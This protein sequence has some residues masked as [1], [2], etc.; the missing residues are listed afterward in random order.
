LHLESTDY[1]YLHGVDITLAARKGCVLESV[2]AEQNQPRL[3]HQNRKTSS[4][5]RTFCLL[6]FLIRRLHLGQTEL[7]VAKVKLLVGRRSSSHIHES[8]KDLIAELESRLGNATTEYLSVGISYKHSAF[9]TSRSSTAAINGLSY[10]TTTTRIEAH[11]V[12]KRHCAES[13]WSHQ[14]KS[15]PNSSRVP[16]PLI[17]LINAHY[18]PVKAARLICKI[19]TDPVSLAEVNWRQLNTDCRW[20]SSSDT[21]TAIRRKSSRDMLHQTAQ[22]ENFASIPESKQS[23]QAGFHDTD[24]NPGILPLNPCSDLDPARKIWSDMRKTSRA[25]GKRCSYTT[26][27]SEIGMDGGSNGSSDV[28][29]SV[30]KE[31][32]RILE[33]AL[34]NKRSLGAD[35]LRS[36]ASPSRSIG[37]GMGQGW[38]WGPPWW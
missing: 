29:V 34:R 10:H 22:L 5:H 36:M 9:P 16:N 3:V 25:T 14:K 4:S 23:T 28:D 20:N 12:I 18:D 1:G 8:S 7:T 33:L 38:G 11:A 37:L 6:S 19:A 35:T 31:Q 30:Q 27:S 24:S 15:N 2:I 17:L 13:S 21:I 26:E 32:T